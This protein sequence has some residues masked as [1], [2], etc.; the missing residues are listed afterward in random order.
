MHKKKNNLR[1]QAAGA[2]LATALSGSAAAF[3]S[4][5]VE[6]GKG[7]GVDM[8][9]VAVQSHWQRQWLRSGEWHVGGY[10]D[11]GLG[12]WD[13]G[14]V[15]AG[16][17]DAIT[18]LGVTPV[19]RLQRND[20]RGAYAEA[21]IGVHYLSRTSL[22]DRRFATQF[23]FGDHLALGYRFGPRGAYDLAYRYQH[24]SNGSIKQPNDGIDFHQLRLQ[25]HF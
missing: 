1:R 2:A 17:N 22:G 5:A 21:G 16:Q 8:A 6:I 14:S 11:F 25:Y 7:N 23:Q 9:R 15:R 18:E 12:Q 10:W 20:R 4:V 24:L 13:R 19:F 3:D